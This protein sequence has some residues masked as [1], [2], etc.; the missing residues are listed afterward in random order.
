M[1]PTHATSDKNMAED[2][3]GQARMKGAYAWATLEKM[4]VL[5][6]GGSDFPV[7]PAE[8]FYGLHAAITRQ[9]RRNQP[10]G[11]WYHNQK[12]SK[13]TAFAM[14]TY[15]AAYAAHQEHQ[16]GT[17]EVGKQADFIIVDHDPFQVPEQD[18]WRI[19]TLQTWV[20]GKPVIRANVQ[21]R[22]INIKQEAS[23]VEFK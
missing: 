1:Q 9:D 3:L 7:E 4:G 22:P 20:N 12:L 15:N 11:G 21:K 17:L 23:A 10:L 2:R 16:I 13:K 6:A 14:F 19:Q 8:P 18:I 5:L